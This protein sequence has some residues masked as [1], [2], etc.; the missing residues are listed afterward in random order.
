MGAFALPSGATR[1][2]STSVGCPNLFSQ[3]RSAFDHTNGHHSGAEAPKDQKGGELGVSS[4]A[5]CPF[6]SDGKAWHIHPTSPGPVPMYPIHTHI[7]EPGCHRLYPAVSVLQV[8][9]QLTLETGS[10][11]WSACTSK[12]RVFFRQ[13]CSLPAPLSRSLRFSSSFGC[14]HTTVTYAPSL[15]P[16]ADL[17]PEPGRRSTVVN[18]PFLSPFLGQRM[19]L[20]LSWSHRRCRPRLICLPCCCTHSITVFRSL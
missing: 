15:V 9:P 19:L 5:T 18:R 1:G 7:L 4:R 8:Q 20:P 16:T 3:I 12:P 14:L 6:V 10:V 2:R 17:N 11:L 13:H